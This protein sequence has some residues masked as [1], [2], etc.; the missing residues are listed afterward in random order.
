MITFIPLDTTEKVLRII[1]NCIGEMLENELVY[2][3]I[4]KDDEEELIDYLISYFPEHLCRE[5]SKKCV[6]VLYEL[7]EWTQD[8]Y[9]HHLTCVHEYA[10]YNVFRCFFK[11]KEDFERVRE[12]GQ[13]N[14]FKFSIKN[15]EN[16]EPEEIET[17]KYINDRSFYEEDLFLDW[18]FL[19]LDKIVHLYQTD[20]EKFNRLGVNLR[21][22]LDI[23]PKDIKE[24]VEHELEG[25]EHEMHEEE[26]IINM[27][28]N[29]I[30]QMEANPVRLEKST[31]NEISDDIKDRLQFSLEMKN[32]VIERESRGGYANNNIGEI[33]FLLY[34]NEKQKYVQIAIG[35]N[36]NWGKF[37]KQIQQLLGYANKNIR[38]GFTIVINRNITYQ[39]VRDEQVKLLKQFDL[40]GKFSIINIKEKGDLLVS[41]HHIPEEKREFRIYHFILNANGQDRKRIAHIARGLNVDVDQNSSLDGDREADEIEDKEVKKILGK[42]NTE[43]SKEIAD[44][45]LKK[46]KENPKIDDMIDILKK[47]KDIIFEE[48]SDKV[49]SEIKKIGVK[50][51]KN[52]NISIEGKKYSNIKIFN[53]EDMPIMGFCEKI[54]NTKDKVNI[55]LSIDKTLK[56]YQD[57]DRDNKYVM[58]Q[59]YVKKAVELA[60]KKYKILDFLKE[61]KINIFICSQ[62]RGDLKSY[63]YQDWFGDEFEIFVYSAQEAAFTVLRQLGLIADVLLCNSDEVVPKSFIKANKKIKVD[64]LKVTREERLIVFGDIFGIT[65]LQNTELNDLAPFTLPDEDFNVLETY[66]AEEILKKCIPN[67]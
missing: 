58:K 40:N 29:V 2:I 10:L 41:T 17:L 49:I 21:Y 63:M 13:R 67:D 66:F 4:C 52:A 18:D 25:E 55:Y 65:V 44:V 33:D 31:E 36:K 39:N 64:L 8:H 15:I 46:I 35:E 22:Y 61:K 42:T 38:F 62:G 11:E 1:N 23:M 45:I 34:K 57:F 26:F 7:Y 47:L 28:K 30:I 24:Y 54:R 16:Y 3:D 6:N 19:W 53:H 14:P 20:R 5:E 12:K 9:F 50:K 59:E 48:E 27:I 60:Q 32:I 43:N 56:E 37:E 51:R